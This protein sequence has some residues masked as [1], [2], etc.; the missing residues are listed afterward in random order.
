MTETMT[1]IVIRRQKPGDARSFFMEHE[2][3]SGGKTVLDALRELRD[4]VDPA[5]AFRAQC[6]SGICGS[7]AVRVNGQARL[8]CNT[9]LSDVAADGK[10]ILEPLLNFA[11]EEDLVVEDEP[12]WKA[13]EAMKPW[14]WNDKGYDH[15]EQVLE[16][17]QNGT[18]C[19]MCSA[20]YSECEVQAVKKSGYTGPAG[21]VQGLRF[22]GDKRDHGGKARL[23]LLE[24]QGLWSCAH[25]YNCIDACPKHIDIGGVIAG[26]RGQALSS[27]LGHN[28]G[29][30]HVTWFTR[31]VRS[32]GKINEFW[33]LVGT[34][35]WRIIFDLPTGIRMALKGKIP[36]PWGSK[37][38]NSGVVKKLFRSKKQRSR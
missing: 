36:W 13:V 7:C 21:F 3:E 9:F 38:K 27:G 25:M 31:G 32:T 5:L 2:V 28:A 35:G 1:T 19:I 14:L 23:K 8:A 16:Q 29:G 10:V 24:Q 11:V 34:R 15:H 37:A 20:C 26:L 22:L 17:V 33:T 4:T 12:F 18:D 30:R 6:K